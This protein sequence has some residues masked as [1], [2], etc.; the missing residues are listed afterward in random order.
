[1]DTLGP[2]PTEEETE[3]VAE[4]VEGN[5]ATRANRRTSNKPLEPTD[6]EVVR[7]EHGVTLVAWMER[8]RR[9]R[10]WVTNDMIVSRADGVATVNDPGAGAPYGV[11]WRRLIELQA[12]PEEVEQELYKRGIWT[13][14]DLRTKPGDVVAAIQAVYGLTRGALLLAAER[15][16]EK[17]QSQEDQ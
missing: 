3:E 13:L 8:N 11:E 12:T 5:F 16:E 10:A 9:R 14:A 17:L 15:Y 7:Q 4:V 1:M 6:V 2:N